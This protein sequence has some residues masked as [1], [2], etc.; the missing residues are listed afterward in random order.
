MRQVLGS[1]LGDVKILMLI[2]VKMGWLKNDQFALRVE[3][4]VIVGLNCLMNLLKG[5][6][7]GLKCSAGRWGGVM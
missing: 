3:E 6:C 7:R 5:S 1:D 4:F 2:L